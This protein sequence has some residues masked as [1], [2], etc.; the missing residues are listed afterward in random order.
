MLLLW[1]LS[2]FDIWPLEVIIYSSQ[3]KNCSYLIKD[4]SIIVAVLGLR[5]DFCCVFFHALNGVNPKSI[6][7]LRWKMSS[8]EFLI[9]AVSKQLIYQDIFS[10]L[11]WSFYLD[12]SIVNGHQPPYTP[13][14]HIR[15][16]TLGVSLKKCTWFS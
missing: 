8:S 11:W 14:L 3:R 13:P 6:I 2:S 4:T 10:N 5:L 1:G 7:D 16:C 15:L 9:Q 12:S